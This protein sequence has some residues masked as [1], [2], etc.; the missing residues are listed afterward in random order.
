[1]HSLIDVEAFL[2]R[3]LGSK[4][5]RQF[6]S[7][8]DEF[9]FFVKAEALT[10]AAKSEADMRKLARET[11]EKILSQSVKT[12]LAENFA[13]E[14]G[15]LSLKVDNGT[16]Y[17]KDMQP[18]RAITVI[19]DNMS[20]ISEVIVENVME[21]FCAGRKLAQDIVNRMLYYKERQGTKSTQPPPPEALEVEKMRL[22]RKLPKIEPHE[23]KRLCSLYAALRD[24]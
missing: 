4:P 14:K 22:E 17:D 8:M 21:Q 13:N 15:E 11:C 6:E 5:T 18:V 9:S 2:F 3:L 12:Y 10:N 19:R 20:K 24:K 23:A 7:N 1:M 16:V